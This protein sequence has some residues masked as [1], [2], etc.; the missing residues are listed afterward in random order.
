MK[1]PSGPVSILRGMLAVA[2]CGLPLSCG[3]YFRATGEPLGIPLKT[4]AIPV[5]ESTSS[6]MGFEAVFTR[7]IREE[8]IS[9]GR[10]PLVPPEQAQ[11]VLSGRIY[12][13]RTEPLSYDL[14]KQRVGGQETTFEMTRSR[15]LKIKLE[16]RLTDRRTGRVIWQE[17]AMQERASFRV[18]ED[19]LVTQFNE[20]R[21]LEAIARD[22]A[23]E[24]FLKTME[25]F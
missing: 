22:L 25:R 24:V 19:P 16:M 18:A 3:Y 12:D 21:A 14:Q 17:K 10:V 23:R 8:F 4:L 7:I 2:L 13:I 11:A 20:Q 6:T 5:I 15:R 9:H 1:D